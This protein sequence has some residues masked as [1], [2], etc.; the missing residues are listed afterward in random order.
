MPFTTKFVS[1]GLKRPEI[2]LVKKNIVPTYS[3]IVLI[4]APSNE[5]LLYPNEKVFVLLKTFQLHADHL[6]L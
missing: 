1:S 2:T 4:I 3:T 5:N 6:L